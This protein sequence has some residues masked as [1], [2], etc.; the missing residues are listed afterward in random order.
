MDRAA[1]SGL[2]VNPPTSPGIADQPNKSKYY[3]TGGASSH[4]ISS[5]S[6][7]SNQSHKK[8]QGPF[9]T[10]WTLAIIAI[11][12]LAIALG[13]GLGAGLAA[14]HKSSSSR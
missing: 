7:T 6:D 12:C 5:H 2:E 8:R 13:A 11:V 3:I 14:Q 9:R 1:G 10:V 4:P